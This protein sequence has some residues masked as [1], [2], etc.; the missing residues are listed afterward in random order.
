MAHGDAA[1]LSNSDHYIYIH[2]PLSF[3]GSKH[4]R[5]PISRIRDA[6]RLDKTNRFS[7]I[8]ANV[9]PLARLLVETGTSDCWAYTPETRT[10]CTIVQSCLHKCVRVCGWGAKYLLDLL[11]EERARNKQDYSAAAVICSLNP[12]DSSFRVARL[13]LLCFCC[14]CKCMQLATRWSAR[15]GLAT[16]CT[17]E[18]R[19]CSSPIRPHVR[20]VPRPLGGML[21]AAALVATRMEF[22][23]S[24]SEGTSSA[25]KWLNLMIS[26]WGTA[27][28]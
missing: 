21:K 27:M 26:W 15:G 2:P 24:T 3:T 23:P 28:K 13:L 16:T 19:R 14:R 22:S 12:G 8:R 5:L 20:S 18:R 7:W 17:S 1:Q 6:T 11:N 4:L 10:I 25:T 9:C